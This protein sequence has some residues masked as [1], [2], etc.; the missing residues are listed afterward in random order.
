MSCRGEN[1]LQPAVA[2]SQQRMQ[3]DTLRNLVLLQP[4]KWSY[5]FLMAYLGS[6]PRNWTR[7]GSPHLSGTIGSPVW[8]CR[9][10]RSAQ[11]PSL[12]GSQAG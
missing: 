10:P 4:K 5:N 3:L 11:A 2:A 1:F 9:P 8:A 7:D 6:G 12:L